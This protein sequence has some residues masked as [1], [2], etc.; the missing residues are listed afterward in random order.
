M[1]WPPHV[2]EPGLVGF[3]IL[4]E[5]SLGQRTL[6]NNNSN[7]RILK[8]EGKDN[9]SVPKLKLFVTIN[10]VLNHSEHCSLEDSLIIAVMSVS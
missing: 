4:C 8:N 9:L 1:P 6:E 7:N 10:S 3:L 5:M 2:V